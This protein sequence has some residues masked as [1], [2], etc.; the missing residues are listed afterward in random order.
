[1]IKIAFINELNQKLG[2]SSEK[3]YTIRSTGFVHRV[4]PLNQK[5]GR[6]SEKIYTI[7]STGFVHRVYPLYVGN[8]IDENVL[9]IT[10]QCS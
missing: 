2:R 9:T 3:I 7:R 8:S 1:M 6:N 5:L 10:H 4:Y